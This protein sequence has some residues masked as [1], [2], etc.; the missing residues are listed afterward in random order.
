MFRL[1]AKLQVALTGAVYGKTLRLSNVARRDRSVGEIVNVM[2]I[3][4]D[5]FQLL[6]SQVQQYWSSPFQITI[7]LVLLYLQLGVAALPGVAIMVRRALRVIIYLLLQ[8]S[9][10][11]LYLFLSVFWPVSA[12]TLSG[13]QP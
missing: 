11:R 8:F 3:D 1:G 9:F 10:F 7:A 4:V 2:A 5:R 12:F 6:T 13:L